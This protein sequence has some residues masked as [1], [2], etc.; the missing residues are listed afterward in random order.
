MAA[1]GDKV[2]RF[3]LV[4]Q[5]GV[6]GMG[7]T[8]EAVRQSGP[9][10]EQRVAIKLADPD[11]LNSHDGILAFRREA[12][13]AASLRHPNIAA[14]IDVD[15]RGGYI[16]CELVDGADLRSVLRAVPGGK[17]AAPVLIHIMAQI[18]RGLSHAHRRVL[19]GQL[20][21]V[22]HR[23]MSPG[24]VVIDYD[25]N[26]KIVDFGIAKAT[27]VA[28]ERAEVVKGK[29]SYMAP[30]Q[31]MGASMDGRLDQYA[32]GVIAYEALSGVRP[33]DGPHDGAT[34]HCI[35]SG[36]HVL[37][38][39]REPRLDSRLCAI[40]E[41]M[42]AL[43]PE[44]RFSS[45]EA[46]LDALGPLTPQYA[47]HRDLIP[48]VT[49]A[50]QPHTIVREN[51]QFVSRP[52]E[53]VEP[54][55]GASTS[56]VAWA[57]RAREDHARGAHEPSLDAML[58]LVAGSAAVDVRAGLDGARGAA[59]AGAE[60]AS[61]GSA[62]VS[63]AKPPRERARATKLLR[64]RSRTLRLT[65]T[66]RLRAFFDAL[67]AAPAFWHGLTLLGALMLGFVAWVALSPDALRLLGWVPAAGHAS[68]ARTD[69]PPGPGAGAR[70]RVSV[71][72][73]GSVWVD[74]RLRGTAPPAL[75]VE[76]APGRHVIEAGDAQPRRSRVIELS[77]GS[78]ESLSF[79]LEGM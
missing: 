76:L 71:S 67:F 52:V 65:V 57:A 33:N 43:Q 47:V 3:T 21:P 77:E 12:A 55:I 50:R 23:D 16:V 39:Q 6:G 70:V 8:W 46:V 20:S 78:V 58:P 14:V 69:A 36:A 73:Q 9:E 24:N 7:E 54:P 11:V 61:A 64:S 32:L 27:A 22:I 15:E 62:G 5:L 49:R 45:L 25:G 48:L 29:L 42:L 26:V 59:R 17:L 2:D 66:G 18:A 30:E 40:V 63:A 60:A 51:G 10:F 75:E 72:P 1:A 31:A 28:G 38:T 34:L 19:R 56:Q 68:V 37:L 35:L 74:Q 53:H 79:D 41:R 4:R 13:L 44:Q